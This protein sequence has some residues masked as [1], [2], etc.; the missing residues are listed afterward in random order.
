ML[1]AYLAVALLPRR[2]PGEGGAPM[3]WGIAIKSACTAKAWPRAEDCQG[4][5]RAAREGRMRPRGWLQRPRGRAK[6]V[7]H[8]G[9][10]RQEGVHI[11]HRICSFSW[12][13]ESHSTGERHLPSYRYLLIPTQRLIALSGQPTC[14]TVA[15]RISG[16]EVAQPDTIIITKAIIT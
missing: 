1:L 8:D 15:R 5:H 12:R 10:S 16:I 6:I 11:D 14:P 13:R 7:S 4:H 2:Q 9:K 3:P